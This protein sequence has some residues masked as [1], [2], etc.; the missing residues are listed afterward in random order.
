MN[1]RV[2]KIAAIVF[3][4]FLLFASFTLGSFNNIDSYAANINGPTVIGVDTSIG[5]GNTCTIQVKGTYEIL[6]S[7]TSGTS[8]NA[9]T[10]TAGTGGTGQSVRFTL[11][12][13][14]GDVLTIQQDTGGAGAAG[15]RNRKG[16]YT[17][18]GGT[19]GNGGN[20]VTVFNNGNFLL[21]VQGGSGGGGGGDYVSSGAS[22]GGG[23][24]GTGG[25]SSG[26]TCITG[27]GSGGAGGTGG[28][29]P[30]AG[31]NGSNGTGLFVDLSRVTTYNLVSGA[32][33][34]SWGCVL[35]LRSEYKNDIAMFQPITLSVK[36]G[37]TY[38][39]AVAKLPTKVKANCTQGLFEIPVT[40]KCETFDQTL[41]GVYTFEGTLGTLPGDV[42]NPLLL[43]PTA[44]ITLVAVGAEQTYDKLRQIEVP[45]LVCIAGKPFNDYIAAY[46]DMA[47]VAADGVTIT[48]ESDKDKV[49]H[50]SALFNTIGTHV[51]QIQ[52]NTFI[53]KV[54]EEPD[55]SNVG[56]A[57]D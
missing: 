39:Q 2:N 28:I 16:S 50:V 41:P 31:K 9:A 1:R 15:G 22:A 47:S 13:N 26:G 8:G 23:S 44:N 36:Y 11:N 33:T 17:A 46:D 54:I 52:G 55:S 18:I 32:Y 24:G 29:P 25:Y 37:T 6:A 7:A 4:A 10:Q 34:G 30:G 27:A 42:K 3:T 56:V 53:F 14:A 20:G 45:R 12:L 35:T 43:F 5:A 49:I 38:E 51:I 21:S 19:G 57:F 48:N 40:W